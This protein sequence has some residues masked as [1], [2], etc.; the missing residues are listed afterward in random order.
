MYKI[1]IHNTFDCSITHIIGTAGW[2]G[3][4]IKIRKKLSVRCSDELYIHKKYIAQ[5]LI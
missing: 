5:C 4:Q 2:V 3:M 1:K